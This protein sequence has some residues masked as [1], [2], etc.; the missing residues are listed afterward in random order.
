MI[1]PD[2]PSSADRALLDALKWQIE[3]GADEAAVRTRALELDNVA[4][5]VGDRPIAKAIYVQDKLL[6]LVLG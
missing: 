2:S 5:H 4:R 3:A 6:N 1:G